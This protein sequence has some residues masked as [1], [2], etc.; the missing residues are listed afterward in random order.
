MGR[1]GSGIERWK[2]LYD[3]DCG[4]CRWSLGRVLALDG[5]RALEP[6]ALDEPEADHLLGG[7]RHDEKM[8]SW[9]LVS[10]D[11]H[12]WSAGDA[13]APLAEALGYPRARRALEPLRRLLVVLYRLVADNRNIWGKLVSDGAKR[14]AD[15]RIAAARGATSSG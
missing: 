9:H 10:P 5:H 8:A 6:V 13:F 4:F 12:R 15:E 7:M 14:R 1:T 3:R 11:G 2:I